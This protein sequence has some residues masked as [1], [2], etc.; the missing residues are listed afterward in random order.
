MSG[1]SR[2]RAGCVSLDDPE[3]TQR[4]IGKS[5]G[6]GES[7]KGVYVRSRRV[8][9]LLLVAVAGT[10]GF[11][12]GRTWAPGDSGSGKVT[13]PFDVGKIVQRMQLAFRAK[14][15]FLEGGHRTYAAQVSRLGRVSFQPYS[16]NGVAGRFL[17]LETTA[18]GR[19]VARHRPAGSTRVGDDGSILMER[20]ICTERLENTEQGLEQSWRFDARPEGRGDL[21]VHV[22][23]H[24]KD[25][26][27]VSSHGHH[28]ASQGAAPDVR[29]GTAT[30]IDAGGQRTQVSSAYEGNEI[31]L[32]VPAEV[33]EGSSYPAMLDPVIS[34]E[35]NMDVAHTLP[36][37]KD[38]RSDVAVG[39]AGSV[40]LVVWAHYPFLPDLA[41]TAAASDLYGARVTAEGSVLDRQTIV[42]SSAPN[43][44]DAAAITSN[45]TDFF[46]V[47]RDVRLG[48]GYLPGGQFAQD[49]YG[50]R[51]TQ[52]GVATDANGIRISASMKAEAPSVAWN[53]TNY[54]VAWTD[55]RNA[56]GTAGI[57]D[58][59]AARV[60][61]AGI[62]LETSGLPVCTAPRHQGG[63]KIACAGAT[64]LVAWS[65]ARN[66][67]ATGYQVLRSEIYGA[68]IN[69]NGTVQDPAGIP[70][71]AGTGTRG[72]GDVASSGA[73]FLVTW[74]EGYQI[75]AAR[76]STAGS[77]LDPSGV[78]V[79]ESPLLPS[80][81]HSFAP[82]VPTIAFDG[83]N[84]LVAWDRYVGPVGAGGVL[85][86]Q[87]YDSFAA[88]LRTD[89]TLLDAT[90]MILSNAR[91]G[92][93]FPKLAFGGGTYLAVWQDGRGKTS[94]T[95]SATD[96]FAARVGANGVVNTPYGINV[97]AARNNERRA[98]VATDGT[99]YLVVWE[100]DRNAVKPDIY[101]AI[102]GPDG[103]PL[104]ANA[105][106]ISTAPDAQEAPAVAF[107]GT[108]YFVVWQDR[109]SGVQYDIYGT[110]VT[111][112]GRVLEA[113][114]IYLSLAGRDATKP[115]IAFG[116]EGPLL[117][118]WQDK[119]NAVS[120]GINA[121]NTDIYGTLVDPRT[122]SVSTQTGILI[123][124]APA[125]NTAAG[126]ILPEDIDADVGF[127]GQ[128]FLVVWSRQERDVFGRRVSRTGTVVDRAE[129]A[130]SP[131]DGA[132]H[133]VPALAYGRGSYLAVWEHL[134]SGNSDIRGIRVRM[135]ASTTDPPP[136]PE[137]LPVIEI[138]SVAN[139][140]ETQPAVAFDGTN[141]L[142]VWKDRRSGTDA[143]W[144]SWISPA[145][146]RLDPQGV[147]IAQD[148][149]GDPLPCAAS[150]KDA[151]TFVVYQKMT[152]RNLPGLQTYGV[153]VSR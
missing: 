105:I 22:A 134:Q 23:T 103:Q 135:K 58:I 139:T 117:V 133:G 28:F 126:S 11:G 136:A 45:G 62:V 15:D 120:P 73:Q 111:P 118:V 19:G 75:K 10:L 147:R 3:S 119:R 30:W 71:A 99:N 94:D 2:A 95:D 32:R 72:I 129:F 48:T 114:G 6:R 148:T 140:P 115:A 69:A 113:N 37:G 14:G 128:Y 74:G 93:V 151:K 91:R 116:K 79:F 104:A 43:S 49:I 142:A 35:I 122:A 38:R 36:Y 40:F 33:V 124:Q 4:W 53:G 13:P 125:V 52:A 108:N 8:V 146:T 65:D 12:A 92:Q 141:F 97:T 145:G 110:R 132:Q 67:T 90:P 9:C 96:V 17:S 101:G 47:W 5:D 61:P 31:V 18:V 26:A 59:Y 24:G 149:R 50:A 27:G 112:G 102:A 86:A 127:D 44:Q 123:G 153:L 78:R 131:N 143:V 54:L 88:R 34:A 70:I 109:R 66:D 137:L 83:T 29:Y 68:R 51:V 64:C 106:P 84:Y 41:R 85:A 57:G 107:D 98:S 20:G 81:G 121:N 76:V 144:G 60:T 55:T 138:S 42:I 63:A 25:Y 130:I 21:L 87:E 100:D 152:T 7:R 46:V 56:A 77:V 89:G 16:E 80:G 150:K 39:F 82:E 1:K